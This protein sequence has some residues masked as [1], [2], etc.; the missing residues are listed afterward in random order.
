MA[1]FDGKAILITGAAY[2]I[3]RAITLEFIREG[4]QATLVDHVNKTKELDETMRIIAGLGGASRAQSLVKD[5]SIATELPSI[6]EAHITKFGRLD[7]LVSN[8]ANQEGASLEKVTEAHLDR[9][10]NVNVKAPLL[11]AHHA[12]KYLMAQPGGN[13]VNLSSLVGIQAFPDR[14]AYSTTKAATDGITRALA[15]DLGLKGIRVNAVAPGHI[16]RN[17]EAQWRKDNT[18]RDQKIFESSYALGRCGTP[19]E[20]AHA[21]LFLASDKAS[22]IT[23]IT[24]MVDGGMSILCPESASFRAAAVNE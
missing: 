14:V 22:F 7:T 5:L 10:I 15:T 23:G 17:G 18:S 11:L 1:A 21:V 19:E 24:L 4:A 13:I 3:G 20:V 8:A 6:I 9:V 16:M 2:S 12:L